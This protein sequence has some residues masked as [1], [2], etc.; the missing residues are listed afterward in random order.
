MVIS[1]QM[2]AEKTWRTANRVERPGNLWLA[3]LL[4]NLAKEQIHRVCKLRDFCSATLGGTGKF[5]S[6]RRNRCDQRCGHLCSLPQSESLST[7][8][9]DRRYR[10]PSSVFSTSD[11]HFTMSLV[12]LSIQRPLLWVYYVRIIVKVLPMIIVVT[13]DAGSD[14]ESP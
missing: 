3:H 13:G 4:L 5:C 9:P 8:N 6:A 14:L 10:F 12:E 7:Q 1:K 2:L 11:K